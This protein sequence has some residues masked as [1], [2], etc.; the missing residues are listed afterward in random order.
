MKFIGIF[1]KKLIGLFRRAERALSQVED[2][3]PDALSVVEIIA[4][5]TPN[6]TD[7]EIADLIT[8]FLSPDVS[9]AHL[10]QGNREE[11]LRMIARLL[12]HK[13]TRLVIKEHIANAALE[14]A[15]TIY[16]NGK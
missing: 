5:A 7:D 12:L 6:R 10:I 2:L 16:K 11:R 1:F 9:V 4:R 14:L 15:Y 3:I 8:E 13:Q